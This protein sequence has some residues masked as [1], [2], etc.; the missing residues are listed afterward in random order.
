M[1]GAGGD[2]K[3]VRTYFRKRSNDK[4]RVRKVP[5]HT[6]TLGKKEASLS[7]P[8]SNTFHIIIL[9]QFIRVY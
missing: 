6:F 2:M 9:V 4:H 3:G 8:L 5:Y 7:S 1:E